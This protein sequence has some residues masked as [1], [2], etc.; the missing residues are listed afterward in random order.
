[1]EITWNSISVSKIKVLSCP[2]I[3]ILS[4]PAFTLQMQ[5]WVV[6]SETLWPAKPEMFTVWPLN[7]S[8]PLS[9][10]IVLLKTWWMFL[11]PTEFFVRSLAS[12]NPTKWHSTRRARIL[13]CPG[14]AVLW[15]EVKW[16]CYGGQIEPILGEKAK[17]YKEGCAETWMCWSQQQI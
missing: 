8:L 1:M 16:L 17:N 10:L 4:M 6:G 9:M 5:S 14:E 2:F 7:K 13:W 11:T 12:T 15:Q 3:C